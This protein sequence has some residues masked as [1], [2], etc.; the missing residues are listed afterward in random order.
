MKRIAFIINF[1]PQKWLGGFNYIY[2]LIHFLKK[3]KIK[4]IEPIIITNNFDYVSKNYKIPNIKVL[5][6]NLVNKN[7]TV[8]NIFDKLQIIIF[9]KHFL[10]EKFLLKNNIYATS[11]MGFTGRKSVIKSYT[12]FPDFQEINLPN[13]FS[14]MASFLRYINL[15]LA[16]K[17]STNLLISSK[18]VLD[19]LR[20]INKDYVKKSILIKHAIDIPKIPSYITSQKILNKYKLSN[21]YFFLP[22][23]LWKHKNHIVVLKALN[24]LKKKVNIKIVA[25]GHFNDHRDSHH[26]TKIM[27]YINS[28]NLNKNFIHLGILPFEEM[29]SLILRSV[30]VINPS[31]SEGWSNTV[32]QAKSL[33]KKVILSDIQTHKE[34]IDKNFFYFKSDSFVQLANVMLGLNDK[35]KKPKNFTKNYQIYKKYV[36]KQK[37]FINDYENIFKN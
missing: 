4:S 18:S 34:Q 35:F 14:L 2:N 20:K 7:N 33:G 3:Y 26:S 5:T 8:K 13:N 31:K 24:Y 22:N 36:L 1:N 37:N 23:H 10:L 12:W 19:D 25:S 11:H 16:F 17:N 15:K 29:I 6:T 30:A 9:G 32:E 27:N 21:N 28:H